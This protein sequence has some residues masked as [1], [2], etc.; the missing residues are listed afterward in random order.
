METTITNVPTFSP[1][2]N[3]ESNLRAWQAERTAVAAVSSSQHMD[4]QLVT[5]EGDKV[6]LSLD[7]K[8]AAM[9][10]T[11]ENAAADEE[12]SSA[13]KGEFSAALYEREMTFTVEGDLS[14]EEKKDIRKALHTLDRMMHNFVNGD[15]KP[16]LAKADK[17]KG[18]ETISGIEAHMSYA[19]TVVVAQQSQVTT[20]SGP[21]PQP[22]VSPV[23][24]PVTSAAPSNP[25]EDKADAVGAQMAQAVAAAQ[26][27][28][29]RIL[30]FVDQLFDDYRRQMTAFDSR[31]GRMVDRVA[32]RLRDALAKFNGVGDETRKIAA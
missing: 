10:G 27:P 23:Q 7:A 25:L 19:R 1:K 31:G 32:S 4:V 14:A 9:F 21:A 26:T 15:L 11:F 17:L 18:L 28:A 3:T 16:M 13:A 5:A 22:A 6:T 30:A 29:E 2:T 12:S 8:A 24:A 20:V